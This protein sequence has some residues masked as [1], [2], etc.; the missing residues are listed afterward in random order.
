MIVFVVVVYVVLI[1]EVWGGGAF[2]MEVM[3][4]AR[5]QGELWVARLVSMVVCYVGGGVY[6][7]W[8]DASGCGNIGAECG[9][10]SGVRARFTCDS[11]GA[12]GD[13]VGVRVRFARD[14]DGT[15]GDMS[16]IVGDES[17]G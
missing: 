10:S 7:E 4:E 9:C 1:L 3:V 15:G 11:D 12:G 5:A 14:S 2:V 16:G 13:V 8:C 6:D 17:G